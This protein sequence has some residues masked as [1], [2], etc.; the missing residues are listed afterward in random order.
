MQDKVIIV[1]GANSGIGKIAARELAKM[2]ATVVMVC[3]SQ[4]RGAAALAD[5]KRASGSSEVHLMLCDMA[6]QD[7]IRN[8]AAKFKSEYDRLDVLL[9]NAGAIFTDRKESSDGIEL[10]FA[11]NHI[12]YYLLTVE[13]IDL[14]KASTPARIVNVSSA[15]HRVN[16]FNFDDYQ[17]KESYSR[18]GFHEYSES[19][20]A[21]LLFTYELA[22]RLEGTGVTVNALHPGFVRTNFSTNN[23]LFAKLVMGVAGRLFGISAEKGAETSIYLASSPDVEGVS[24]KYFSDKKEHK[25]TDFSHNVEAQ[26]R[27]WELSAEL[28]GATLD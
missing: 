5:I 28:T 2:G 17:R 20:M 8:F 7:S 26:R 22:R 11:V 10:T 19:K 23:G 4:E 16:S 14:L 1:T 13:L 9:N 15:A 27:L 6:S 12:G 18:L 25:S 24:G 21:N 3:R